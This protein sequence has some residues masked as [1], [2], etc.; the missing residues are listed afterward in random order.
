M[1]ASLS[2]N[3]IN[4]GGIKVGN[5]VS[6]SYS[7]AAGGK[8]ETKVTQSDLSLPFHDL[9][10]APHPISLLS[11]H[12]TLSRF[13]GRDSEIAALTRWAE[14][15]TRIST[16]IISGIGGTGKSRL[17]A[18][19]SLQSRRRGWSAG[20]VSLENE[21]LYAA[22]ITGTL[23]IIDYPEERQRLVQD[24]LAS[25]AVSEYPSRLRVLLLTRRDL[26]FWEH[27]FHLARCENIIDF[28]PLA[29]HELDLQSLYTV[30][31]S[32]L[33]AASEKFNTFPLPLSERDFIEW[34]RSSP[35]NRLP[36]FVMAAAVHAAYNPEDVA[37]RYSGKQVISALVKRELQR[38]QPFSASLGLLPDTLSQLLAIAT[39]AGG[40]SGDLLDK[41]CRLPGLSQIAPSTAKDAFNSS[42]LMYDG[43]IEAFKPDIVA[44]IMV[45]ECLHEQDASALDWIWFA[46]NVPPGIEA[47]CARIARIVQDELVV[48]P[49]HTPVVVRLLSG[50][51]ARKLRLPP[52]LCRA[53]LARYIHRM[54]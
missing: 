50:V 52:S 3:L 48:A 33:D 46:L 1:S 8:S 36:L 14:E 18:E 2:F 34:A 31:N 44:A 22:S 43:R 49:D 15:P 51:M 39:L 9:A 42:D 47:G 12:T 41:C 25:L 29:L 35:E 10:T 32:T 37:V 19:F 30:Y 26:P 40:L 21:C 27:A 7:P 45:A 11:W 6:F 54:L 38:L 4:L 16:K 20:F 5:H 13:V 24:F 17:A 53:I 23:L 28:E